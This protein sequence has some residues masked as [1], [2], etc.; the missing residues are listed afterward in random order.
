[1]YKAKIEYIRQ[2]E[3]YIILILIKDKWCRYGDEYSVRVWDFRSDA[4]AFIEE[5]LKLELLEDT[6]G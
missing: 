2:L 6:E 3:G 5:N 1:M 4:E